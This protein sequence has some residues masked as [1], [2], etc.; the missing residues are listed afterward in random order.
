M[1]QQKK[2]AEDLRR[3]LDVMESVKCL[4]YGNPNSIGEDKAGLYL[5]YA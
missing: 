1:V 2:V 4:V 3:F 5:T